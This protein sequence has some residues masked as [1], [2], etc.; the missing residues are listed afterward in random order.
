MWVPPHFPS[1]CFKAQTAGRRRV[2]CRR[3]ITFRQTLQCVT[4]FP[5]R[6]LFMKKKLLLKFEGIFD[7]WIHS[8][9]IAYCCVGLWACLNSVL[10]DI[11]YLPVIETTS[12]DSLRP[13]LERSPLRGNF[14]EDQLLWGS[15]GIVRGFHGF[16]YGVGKE[17]LHPLTAALIPRAPA[18]D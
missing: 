2:G 12:R 18:S 13:L 3:R 14:G 8:E 7:S 6:S 10:Y 15:L 9:T 1:Q 11:V 17:A 16:V 5:L 4:L